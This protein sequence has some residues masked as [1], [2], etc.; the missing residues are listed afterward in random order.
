M[1]EECLYQELLTDVVD[2][3]LHCVDHN[4]L[5]QRPLHEV[6]PP[7]QTFHQVMYR[8]VRNH[9][10]YEAGLKGLSYAPL[11]LYKILWSVKELG[12][13]SLL[14]A[15]ITPIYC[16]ITDATDKQLYIQPCSVMLHL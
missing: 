1:L 11:A 5:K 8:T 4:H 10:G 2:I 7:V 12:R 15:N 6:F 9:M 16:R 13:L 3:I 14:D